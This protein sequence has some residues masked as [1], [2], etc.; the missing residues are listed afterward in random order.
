MMKSKTRWLIWAALLSLFVFLA[1][2]GVK[3][4]DL[5]LIQMESSTL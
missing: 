3:N 1:I 4:G 2:L 5:I